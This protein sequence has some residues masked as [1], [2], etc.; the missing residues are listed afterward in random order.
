MKI[1][2]R[3]DRR[4]GHIDIWPVDDKAKEILASLTGGQRKCFTPKQIESIKSMG[5]EVEIETPT[6]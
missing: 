5:V 4:Y 2:V 6:I 1:T 3:I